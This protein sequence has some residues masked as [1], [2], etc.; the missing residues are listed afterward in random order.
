MSS[1]IIV[2]YK[3]QGTFTIST[4]KN[5][6]IKETKIGFCVGPLFRDFFYLFFF[7]R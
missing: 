6:E 1:T 3:I 2:K 5:E 4:L 7:I